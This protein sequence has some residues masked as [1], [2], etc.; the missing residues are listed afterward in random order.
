M[1]TIARGL[2]A[3]TVMLCGASCSGESPQGLATHLEAALKAGNMDDAMTLLDGRNLPGQLKFFYMTLV[4]DC[5]ENLTCTVTSGPLTDQFRERAKQQREE[6]I[7]IAPE[8]EGLLTV[9]KEGDKEHGSTQLPFAK[10]DGKYRVIAGRYGAAK[11]AQL[12]GQSAQGMV[13][14]ALANGLDVMGGKLDVEWKGKAAVL[15]AGGGAA[16]A[17]FAKQTDAVAAAAKAKDLDAMLAAGGDWARV[18]YAEKDY[19]GKPVSVQRRQLKMR[20]QA[21]RQLADIT[22]TGG[23]EADDVAIVTYEGHDGA[24]FTVRGFQVLQKRDGAWSNLGGDSVSI[25]PA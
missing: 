9:K 6:G 1:R 3:A 8:P 15:P 25:P 24:G 11:V 20:A 23:Y 13:D 5:F 2:C 19:A 16:G 17:A 7:E 14:E 22:V 10:V 18:V 21:V 4:P 12:K